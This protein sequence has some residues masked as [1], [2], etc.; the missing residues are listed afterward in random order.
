MRCYSYVRCLVLAWA[1]LLAGSAQAVSVAFINPGNSDEIYWV[2]A[3]RAMAAAASSLG[4]ELEVQY[5]QRDPLRVL[6]LARALVA[7]PKAQRPDYV[8]FSNDSATGVELLRL[9]DGSGIRCFMAFS[10]F[11]AAEEQ[12]WGKPRQHF[13]QWIGSL[14]PLAEEAGYLTGKALIQAGR[15]ARAQAADGKLHLLAIA[16]DRST[17]SSVRRNQGLRRALAEAD[18]VVLDQMVYAGWSREKAAEK[19][20]WLYDR[21]PSARLLWAGNDLIAFGAMQT[22]E[23]RG[24][25]PGKSMRFSGINTSTEAMEALKSGR[26]TALAGGHF[27]AGAWSLVMLFDYHHGRDFADEGLQLERPMF[28]LFTPAMAEKFEARFGQRYDSVDFRRYSKVLNHVTTR[29]SFE[30]APLLY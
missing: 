17:I 26:L 28:V 19:S 5:A 27:M 18:D 16:G 1:V 11:T 30:F 20:A 7:R 2:G 22:L 12:Q 6:A 14:E 24:G 15:A 25:Q 3:A 29:Y 13:K 4:W 8:V 21:Y 23:Q 9:F 10:G